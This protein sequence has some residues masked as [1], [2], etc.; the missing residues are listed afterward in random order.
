MI[1]TNRPNSLKLSK[2]PFQTLDSLNFETTLAPNAHWVLPQLSATLARII[3]PKK[4]GDL[5][6]FRATSEDLRSR[7]DNLTFEDREPITVDHLKGMF[8]VV[9]RCPRG[10]SL[11]SM[12]QISDGIRYAANVP[13]ALAALKQY[14]NINYSEWDWTDPAKKMFLDEDMVEMSETFGLNIPYSDDP[15]HFD[16]ETLM[17]YQT[18]SRLV[19]TGK[20]A[21]KIRL[22]N[23]TVSI[24]KTGDGAFDNLPRFS[25]LALCQTW[26]FQPCHYHN[27]MISNLMNIDAPPVPLVS[28]EVVEE[29]SRTQPHVTADSYYEDNLF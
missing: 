15:L 16:Q 11:G 2:F 23:A 14:K 18:N 7:A 10:S 20:T 26:I 24:T 21:G 12:K 9:K 4:L 19:K 3:Q 1:N 27:L 22:L 13:L 25:K 5:Y 17:Q 28:T 8:L 6:S 29:L